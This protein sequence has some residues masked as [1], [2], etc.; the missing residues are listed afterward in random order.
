[1]KRNLTPR[2]AATELNCSIRSIYRLVADGE[3]A[4][5]NIRT[6]LRITSESLDQY[7]KRQILKFQLDNG[8]S[9]SRS[10]SE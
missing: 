9:V 1:M 3:L 2:E 10:D 5:F 6:C 4:A 8:I 7:R